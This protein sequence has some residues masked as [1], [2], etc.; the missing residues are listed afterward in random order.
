[1]ER[2]DD[3]ARRRAASRRLRRC[4][5]SAPA[6][7]R[8]RRCG[9][10]SPRV[11][12]FD[13]AVIDCDLAAEPSTALYAALHAGEPIPT[14]S[15]SAPS[16]ELPDGLGGNGDEVA[17]KPLPAEALVYRLQALLIRSGRHLPTE[18]GE[19][20][21]RESLT[22]APIAGEGH[23]VERLRAE[24]RRRQDDGRGQRGRRAAPADSRRGAPVRR[25]RR[26]R[27]RDLGPRR[28]VPDGP[29]RPGGQPARGM[30]RCGLRA[31]RRH[32]TPRAA[33]A[34]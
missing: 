23:V 26:R 19:W 10:T 16:T 20:A 17:L 4:A 8:T 14:C 22:T 12:P 6:S 34:C 31:G 21:V 3:P 2:P 33:S 18:S 25:R 7:S 13:L 9:G 24:G 29:R 15:C 30:D 32:A 5:R 27:Q 28:A 11:P 1:M